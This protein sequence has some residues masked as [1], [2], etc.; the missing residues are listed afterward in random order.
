MTYTAGI[1]IDDHKIILR[2]LKILNLSINRF[3]KVEYVSSEIFDKAIE[4]IHFYI[5]IYHH[6][7]E[8]NV[9]FKGIKERGYLFDEDVIKILTKEH[10]LAQNY[11]FKFEEA[12]D[13]FKHGDENARGDIIENARKFSLLLSHHIH[14]EN[15]IFSQLSEQV[16]STDDQNY[17]LKML[18][19]KRTQLGYDINYKYNLLVEEME[20]EHIY[21]EEN[22]FI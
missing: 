3:E 10:K 11:I 2:M 12:I 15:E 9:L 13:R 6:S 5:D 8:E 21:S 22:I 20:R 18:E 17:L 4:F 16:I 7:A 14:K 19:E 1:L